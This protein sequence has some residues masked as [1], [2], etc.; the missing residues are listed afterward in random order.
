MLCLLFTFSTSQLILANLSNYTENTD[1]QNDLAY[2]ECISMQRDI[3]LIRIYTHILTEH[4][5]RH[6][7]CC[8]SPYV[9]VVFFSICSCTAVVHWTKQ[10][11]VHLKIN[12]GMN[13]ESETERVCEWSRNVNCILDSGVI[14]FLRVVLPKK[15]KTNALKLIIKNATKNL[16]LWYQ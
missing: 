1:L 6:R 8:F 5:L 14:T 16:A 11:I 9:C 15:K 13:G 12:H 3:L 4:T 2:N 7:F 10:T